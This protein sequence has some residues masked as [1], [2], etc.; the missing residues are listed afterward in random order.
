MC[1]FPQTC[2]QRDGRDHESSELGDLR[3]SV[4]ANYGQ[5]FALAVFVKEWV[6]TPNVLCDCWE[7]F[8]FPRTEIQEEI[9]FVSLE[10]ESKF[11]DQNC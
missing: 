11:N 6:G 7:S 3:G 4:F 2:G 8:L 5:T 9:V 10:N 1:F